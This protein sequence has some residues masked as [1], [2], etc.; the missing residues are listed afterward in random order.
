M[1]AIAGCYQ[2]KSAMAW[3]DLFEV[4]GDER[5]RAPYEQVLETSLATYRDFLPGHP[6]RHK[7]MDRLHA[8]SY[9]LEGLLPRASFD[10]RCAAA[11]AD[12]IDMVAHHLR[13]IAPEFARSDVFAQLLRARLYAAMPARFR[14]TGHAPNG[15][16]PNSPRSS[17]PM[18]DTGLGVRP[19]SG[20][21]FPI[22]FPLLSP[23]RRSN[24]GTEPWRRANC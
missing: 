9:F 13:D 4:T 10:P 7:V 5:F 23:R 21:R 15:R 24:S 20:C 22:R 18:A 12:G 11:L 19:A 2:L 8:F 3:W 1:V 16:L 17:A 14:S 6:E